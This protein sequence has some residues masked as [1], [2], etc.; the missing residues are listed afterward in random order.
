[1]PQPSTRSTPIKRRDFLRGLGAAGALAGAALLGGCA[2]VP[3]RPA[4]APAP[5]NA[6]GTAALPTATPLAPPAAADPPAPAA[7]TARIALVKTGDRAA[8]VRQALALFG[9]PAV[10]GKS[11]FL[12]PNFNSADPAPGSTHPDVLRTLVTELQAGSPARIVVGDRSGMGNTRQVMEQVGAFGLAD[13]LGFEAIVFDELGADGWQHF[14][15]QGSHWE[16]GFALPKPML[17]ADVFVQTCCLKT[18][19]FG[20]HF[21]LSLK[22]NVGLA[23]KTVPGEGYNY[24]GELHSSPHQ[25]RMIAEINAVFPQTLIVLDGVEAFRSGGPD[26]GDKVAAN[27]LLVGDDPVAVDAVG[28]ALLRLLGTTPA[29]STGPIFAQEQLA[30]AIELGVGVAGGAGIELVTADAAGE[31]YA[32]QIRELLLA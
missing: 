20:G 19:R 13:E 1:M 10:E 18:H 26:Q 3:V 24:M 22:N 27:V 31:E 8:G 4:S 28:V 23:A 2:A 16:R 25:R 21:T 11:V 7:K 14:N 30:R 15:P 6:G 5:G 12:K 17:E 9:M 32:S 29:V